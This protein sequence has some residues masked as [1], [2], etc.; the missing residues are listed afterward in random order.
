MPHVS[1]P[2]IEKLAVKENHAASSNDQEN[3]RKFSRN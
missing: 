1:V 2:V 3:G